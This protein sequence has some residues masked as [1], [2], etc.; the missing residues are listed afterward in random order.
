MIV[1]PVG[2][3]EFPQTLHLPLEERR[4]SLIDLRFKILLITAPHLPHTTSMDGYDM[5]KQLVNIPAEI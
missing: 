3:S 2:L 4:I 1:N 5:V